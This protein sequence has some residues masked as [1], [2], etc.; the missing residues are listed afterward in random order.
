MKRACREVEP[1]LAG[2]ALGALDPAELR[3]VE[4]HLPGCEQCSAKAVEHGQIAGGLL[5]LP[6]RTPSPS[7]RAGLVARLAPAPQ[8]GRDRL[9]WPPLSRAAT[10]LAIA[11]FLLVNGV[12]FAQLRSVAAGQQAL[13][14]RLSEQQTVTALLSYP[15]TKVARV[16]GDQGYGTF[17]YDP[18]QKIAVLNAWG[19]PPLGS[20]QTYQAW[21]VLP[22]SDRVSGGTFSVQSDASFT[23]LVIRSSAPLS[24]YAGVGVT[25]EPAGGS[26][27][28]SGP[29]V[30]R[31][32]L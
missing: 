18:Y 10:A 3:Q 29:R 30:L 5:H 9:K 23:T 16:T 1:L 32:N 26:L 6:F 28:P 12:V 21:L 25:I 19:L 11:A 27:S 31:A 2:Y 4:A 22:N 20:G 7:V 17:V 13:A 8:P 15:S 24:Q 14:Q